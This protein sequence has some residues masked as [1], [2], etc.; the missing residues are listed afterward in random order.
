MNITHLDDISTMITTDIERMIRIIIIFAM[1][2]LIF[3]TN[4]AI[5]TVLYHTDKLTAN[6]T[7]LIGSLCISDLLTGGLFIT[8]LVSAFYEKWVFGKLMCLVASLISAIVIS[9]TTL[10]LTMMIVDKFLFLRYPLRY[11][12]VK[13]QYVALVII[14]S[15]VVAITVILIFSTV[16]GYEAQY[17][18]DIYMCL[19][20]FSSETDI[21]T[22]VIAGFAISSPLGFTYAYYNVR[23]YRICQ[24]HKNRVSAEPLDRLNIVRT[25]TINTKGL[26]TIFIVTTTMV[27]S[28]L[29]FSIIRTFTWMGYINPP[30]PVLFMAYMSLYCTSFTNWIIYTKTHPPY[31]AEQRKVWLKLKNYLSSTRQHFS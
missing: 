11:H 3:T 13:K 29:P 20:E 26:K 19:V 5:A 1:I 10:T 4:G 9:L 31:R 12:T 23:I 15:W 14:A 21:Q 6:T 28:L 27:L 18:S 8:T 30:P 24:N 16:F 17:N 25:H 7:Y 22:A 2:F